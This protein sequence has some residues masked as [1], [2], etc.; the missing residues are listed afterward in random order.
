MVGVATAVVTMTLALGVLLAPSG[1]AAV[2][3]A[4]ACSYP[5]WAEGTSYLY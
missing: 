4:V 3:P 2:T 5:A 1:Q